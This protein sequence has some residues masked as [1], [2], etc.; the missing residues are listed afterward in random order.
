MNLEDAARDRRV[1][2]FR[3]DRLQVDGETSLQGVWQGSGVDG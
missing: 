2:R 1:A 3:A